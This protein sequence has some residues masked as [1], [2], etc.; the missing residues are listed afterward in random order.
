[1]WNGHLGEINATQH[2]IT[3]K[4]EYVPTRQPPYRAGHESREI[5]TAQVNKMPQAGVIEPAQSEW[6]S[7]VVIVTKKDGNPRFCVDYRKL[8]TAT[9]RDAYPI[10]R[11]DDCI[12]SLGKAR[13]FLTL[14]CN[15]G[16]WQIP[17]APEDREKTAFISHAGAW[18]FKRM[19]FGLTNAPATFHRA[20]D[21]LLAGV[22]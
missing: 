1:M 4:P 2:R 13:I 22:K 9:I 5:I 14:D 17:V 6:A 19:P 18:Q 16:Y 7:P 8:N 3:L 10:S 12:E 20:L 15:G 11:M 21:I